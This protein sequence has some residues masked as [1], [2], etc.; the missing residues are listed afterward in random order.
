VPA[1]AVARA[2]AELHGFA[3]AATSANR[4]GAPPA[5]SAD[6][7]TAALEAH[8]DLLVDGGVTSGGPPSTIVELTDAGPVQRRAGAIAWD[9]VLESL[10]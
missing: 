6:D 1:H 9:R 10:Q 3:I 7:V 8:V 4:S 5:S 2:L